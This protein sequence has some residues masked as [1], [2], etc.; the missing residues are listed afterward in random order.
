MRYIAR[1]PI[2]YIRAGTGDLC[3]RLGIRLTELDVIDSHRR[4]VIAHTQVDGSVF[5]LIS[6]FTALA[7]HYRLSLADIKAK[8]A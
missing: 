2:E 3:D 1:V 5:A 6:F 8:F 4:G 7:T